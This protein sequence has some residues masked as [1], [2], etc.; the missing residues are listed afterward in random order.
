MAYKIPIIHGRQQQIA[1]PIRDATATQII[2]KI[3]SKARNVIQSLQNKPV[4]K[5]IHMQTS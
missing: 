1:I 3:T 2:T 5:S 4:N